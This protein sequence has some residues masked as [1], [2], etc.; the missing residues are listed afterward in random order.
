MKTK[1][2]AAIL[3]IACPLSLGAQDNSGEQTSPKGTFKIATGSIKAEDPTA[4]EYEQQYV[5]SVSDPKVRERLGEPRQ[6]QPAHYFISPNEQWIF[7]MIH[8]GSR[9][10]GGQLFKRQ[11]GLK[12]AGVEPKFEES[13]W[14]F[15]CQNEHVNEDD[16]ETGIIDFVAW[17]PDSARVLVD[18]RA[19]GFGGERER[20]VYKWYAY[21]N[22][23]TESF[24]LTNY[25]RRLNKDAWKR[26]RGDTLRENFGEAASAEPLGELPTEAESKKRYEAAETHIKESFQ[27]LLDAQEKQLEKTM[28]NEQSSSTQRDIYK[29]QLQGTRGYQQSWIKTR[30]SGAKFYADAGA[31]STV[32]RRYWQ[33]MADSSE[34]RAAEIEQQLKQSSSN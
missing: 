32:L 16:R 27:K 18:L 7:A 13:V 1:L 20:S 24:E 26:Y 4:D 5:V 8:Y 30:E 31:K 29:Q 15:F 12:F 19:G 17:S 14:R 28:N 25:L 11:L 33:H 6:A 23:R 3:S 10:G 34:A 9:M 21:F 22:T 2:A